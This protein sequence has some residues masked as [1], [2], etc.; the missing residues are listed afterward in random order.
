MTMMMMISMGIQFTP[1][2][3]YAYGQP[4]WNSIDRGKLL[5]RA[6]ELYSNPTSE[7]SSIEAE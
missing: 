6:R 3:I 5:I 7:S 2:V 4:W 1:Q